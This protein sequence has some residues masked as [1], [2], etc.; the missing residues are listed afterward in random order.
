MK[1]V[2]GTIAGTSGG[3]DVSYRHDKYGSGTWELNE[4]TLKPIGEIEETP[5]WPEELKKL[6]SDFPGMQV[7]WSKDAGENIDLNV[8]YILRWETLGVNR[9][10]RREIVPKPTMLRLYKLRY[11]SR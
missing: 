2:T 8:Q 4:T 11:G 3:A 10:R 9:D 7:K 1:P 5:L 6:E